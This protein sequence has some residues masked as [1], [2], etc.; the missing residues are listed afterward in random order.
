MKLIIAVD[1]GASGGVAIFNTIKKHLE[2]HAMPEDAD[3]RDLL[4]T[5]AATYGAAHI[6]CYLEQVG[7]FINVGGVNVGVGPA[8]FNFGDGFGYVRGIVDT[9]R[10][11]RVMVRPQVW[12][13]GIPGLVPKMK[14]NLRKRALKE[15]AARLFP[16]QK[17]T[18]KTADALALL[19]YAKRIEG[20]QAAPVDI[21]QASDFKAD[22]RGA[23]KWCK[24]NGWPV[25]TEHSKLLAMV[26]YWVKNGR[27]K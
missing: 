16:D 3:L 13:K 25:P 8:M 22:A 20:G 11:R 1:P 26:N 18:L 21:P 23:K 17:V 10:I 2:I 27:P 7:G 14:S 24:A 4:E 12:Q 5:L 19:E 15:Y 6:V 9:L